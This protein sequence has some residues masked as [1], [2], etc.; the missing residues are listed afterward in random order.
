MKKL[1]LGIFTIGTLFTTYSCSNT[2]DTVRADLSAKKHKPMRD[3]NQ[4]VNEPT[5]G[6]Q[7]DQIRS[8]NR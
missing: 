1:M 5:A 4:V 8:N 3:R 6:H 2:N 7:N